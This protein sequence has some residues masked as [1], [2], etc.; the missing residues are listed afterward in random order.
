MLDEES[1]HNGDRRAGNVNDLYQALKARAQLTGVT[2]AGVD[3]QVAIFRCVVFAHQ[4][5]TGRTRHSLAS[6]A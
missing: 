4:G 1:Q 6:L 2:A 5:Q 3:R